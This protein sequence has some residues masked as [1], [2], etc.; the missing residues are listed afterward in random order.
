[1]Q[2]GADFVGLWLDAPVETLEDA[3]RGARTAM[4]PMRTVEIVASAA[5]YETGRDRLARGSTPA[6]D[7]ADAVAE[8]RASR[9]PAAAKT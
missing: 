7:P 8:S 4:P 5:E 9:N 3:R 2:P 6:M 1:M